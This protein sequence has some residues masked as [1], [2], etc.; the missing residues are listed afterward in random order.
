[1]PTASL[2]QR[3]RWFQRPSGMTAVRR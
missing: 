3:L 2:F 1:L